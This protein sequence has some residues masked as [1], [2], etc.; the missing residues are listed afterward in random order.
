MITL[1]EY[2]ALKEIEYILSSEQTM[3]D[4]RQGEEDLKAGKG[5]EVNLDEL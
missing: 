4:I 1:D 2:N 5:I 3:K